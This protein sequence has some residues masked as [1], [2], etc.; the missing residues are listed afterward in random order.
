[1][2]LSQPDL[3]VSLDKVA[4]SSLTVT[5]NT[6]LYNAVTNPLGYGLPNGAAVNDVTDVVL[7]LTYSTLSSDLVYTMEV[8]NGV[9][10]ACT[11]GF[12]GATPTDIIS[13]LT[14]T[15]FPLNEFPIVADYGVD[16]PDF[17]DDVFK[18]TCVI[19][20]EADDNGTPTAF[21]YTAIDYEPVSCN[22][23][24]CID[25]MWIAADPNCPTGCVNKVFRAQAILNQF[26]VA[27]ENGDLDSATQS[28][29]E[30]KKYCDC[31]C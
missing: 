19:S 27:C 29:L 10:T 2:A 12:G 1:M 31:G 23:Q 4:C 13:V 8:T 30:A 26:E 25:K 7:T 28:L 9:I 17:D 15:D 6:G 20:G 21:E 16:I 5:D 18:V 24:C 14:N 3:T 22:T 11:L